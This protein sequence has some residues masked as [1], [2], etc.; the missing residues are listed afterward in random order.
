[1]TNAGIAEGRTPR[2]NYAPIDVKITNRRLISPGSWTI[3][4]VVSGMGSQTFS[5]RWG[6]EADMWAP[7][8]STVESS[9]TAS[10]A[11]E[12]PDTTSAGASGTLYLSGEYITSNKIPGTPKWPTALPDW[13]GPYAT[14][15]VFPTSLT[16][17]GIELNDGRQISGTVELLDPRLSARDQTI[18]LD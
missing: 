6:N 9:A 2:R 7:C 8:P 16:I 14:L 3:D 12:P 5:A 13:F 1:N 11:G 18:T 10:A 4:F 17:T 15:R